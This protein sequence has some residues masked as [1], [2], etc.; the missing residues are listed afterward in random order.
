MIGKGRYFVVP[1]FVFLTP[2]DL[3]MLRGM[4]GF[5]RGSVAGPFGALTAELTS[6][7][8]RHFELRTFIPV[9]LRYLEAELRQ[10]LQQSIHRGALTLSIT[11][12]YEGSSPFVLAPNVALLAGIK[13]A[14]ETTAR[15]LDIDQPAAVD[16]VLR[17]GQHDDLLYH[18]TLT[19]AEAHRQWVSEALEQALEA[20][21]VMKRREGEAI[22]ND[23]CKRLTLLQGLRSRIEQIAPQATAE[24]RQRLLQRLADLK[25]KLDDDERILREVALLADKCDITEELVRVGH[26]LDEMQQAIESDERIGGKV[27]EFR[28]QELSRE[29]NTIGSKATQVAISDLAIAAKAELEKI[30]EQLQN[31]E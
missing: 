23:L 21:L 30:R 27:L 24:H 19:D 3:T 10:Q 17:M 12:T 16:I 11:T 1:S 9:H 29:I 25:L 28:M 20:M 13:A 18:R 8:R 4:T 14:A 2:I 7:N 5:G 26:H 22:A 15:A 31:V 6:L